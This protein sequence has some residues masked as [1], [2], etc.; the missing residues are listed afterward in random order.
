M[1]DL[2]AWVSERIDESTPASGDGLALQ[3]LLD[4]CVAL[5]P[6]GAGTLFGLA[7]PPGFTPSPALYRKACD[8]LSRWLPALDEASAQELARAVA[9]HELAVALPA[10]LR[11]APIETSPAVDPDRLAQTRDRLRQLEPLWSARAW[12]ELTDRWSALTDR[13]RAGLNGAVPLALGEPASAEAITRVEDRIGRRLPESLLRAFRNADEVEF[14][15]TLPAFRQPPEGLTALRAGG[16]PEGLWRLS[17]L[18]GL[19]HEARS[20]ALDEFD[21]EW[22]TSVPFAGLNGVYLA[23][24]GKRVVFLDHERDRARGHGRVLAP[25]LESFVDRWTALGCP[26]P[27]SWD[28]LAP[29]MGADGLDP[30]REDSRR[31]RAWLRELAARGEA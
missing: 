1:K 5:R 11:P 31:W 13:G 19:I 14:E 16:F 29:F 9:R 4:A 3:R 21:H 28:R 12:A 8:A 10:E 27:S 20:W 18:P 2:E 6:G 15:W 26:D 23:L 7:P 22:R 25:D 17:D 24:M 30:E